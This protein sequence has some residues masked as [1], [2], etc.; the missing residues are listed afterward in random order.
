MSV[1]MAEGSD[2][3]QRA[4]RTLVLIALG[5]TALLM[6]I[7]L[8]N[9]ILPHFVRDAMLLPPLVPF[10]F[11]AIYLGGFALVL[12]TVLWLAGWILEGFAQ[13]AS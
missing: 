12:G 10:V 13:H 8:L 4:G 2:R 6:L 1:N 7:M 5:I 3:M 9:E 11:L